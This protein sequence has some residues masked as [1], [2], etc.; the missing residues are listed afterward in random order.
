MRLVKY[1]FS[2]QKLAQ[3]FFLG[4]VVTV[5]FQIQ[6]FLLDLNA[7]ESGLFNPFVSI[8]LTV[9]DLFLILAA[10]FWGIAVWQNK[11]SIPDLS[12]RQRRL[13]LLVLVFLASLEL[14]LLFSEHLKVSLFYVFRFIEFFL[15]YLLFSFRIVSFHAL[16]RAFLFSILFQSFL[17]LFQYLEQSNLWFKFLGEPSFGKETLDVA[18]IDFAEKQVVRPYG[19]FAHPNILA[20]Y[21]IVGIFLSLFSWKREKVLYTLFL[22]VFSLILL[23]TF[24]RS[25]WLA[26]VF[27]IIFYFSTTNRKVPFLYITLGASVV[28]LFVIVFDLLPF[29]MDSIIFRVGIFERIELVDISKLIFYENPLGVGLGNFTLVMQD[30]VG[31]KLDPWQ[32]QPVHNAFVLLLVEG[33]IVVLITFLALYLQIFRYIYR[34]YRK[35]KRRLLAGTLLSLWSALLVLTLFDHYLISLYQG[36]FLFWFFLAMVSHYLELETTPLET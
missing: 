9:S 27:G 35:Y 7:Y 13:M 31:Y 19:T 21:L 15:F 10:I 11:I 6:T 20:A 1:F 25:A 8:F 32:L 14:S 3:L 18:K 33:G 29:I 5:P 22:I 16:K 23:L 30:Y 26:L 24:S 36:Q 12:D 34:L 17:A 2:V 28:F 4:F